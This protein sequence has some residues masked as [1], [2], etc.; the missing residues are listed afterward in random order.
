MVFVAKNI[1]ALGYATFYLKKG[2]KS[3]Q[4]NVL[5]ETPWTSTF[6]NDFYK[7]TPAN[8][9]LASIFDKSLQ[10]KLLEEMKGGDKNE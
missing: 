1:Q 5:A 8:A 4:A 2:G 9:S 10:K 3:Q 7:I 6:E